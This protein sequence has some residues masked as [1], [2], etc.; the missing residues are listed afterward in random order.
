[1]KIHILTKGLRS[2]NGIAF[3]TPLILNQKR[4]LEIGVTIEFF[5]KISEKLTD[6]DI[7]IL[8]SK[9]FV[10]WW[11]NSELLFNTLKKLKKKK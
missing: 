6:C 11:Q 3:L 8:E 4:F 2:Y 7:L 1:M 5:T 10:S 9:F